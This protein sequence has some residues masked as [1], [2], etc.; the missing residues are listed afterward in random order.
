MTE[1][2]KEELP[3]KG[4]NIQVESSKRPFFLTLVAI[5]AFIFIGFYL[6]FNLVALFNSGWIAKVNKQYLQGDD[7]PPILTTLEYTV[8]V[9]L[10]LAALVGLYLMWK[11]KRKGYLVF[12]GAVL[13]I[14]S[15]QLFTNGAPVMTTFVNIALLILLGTFYQRFE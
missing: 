10:H 9:F 2:S 11:L 15:I 13:I 5:F 4:G 3:A 8:G 6:L 1:T 7:A 12:S 14:S